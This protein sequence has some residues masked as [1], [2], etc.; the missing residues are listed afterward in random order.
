MNFE[1]KMVAFGY[2]AKE[3][4]S[5]FQTESLAKVLDKIQFDSLTNKEKSIWAKPIHFTIPNGEGFRRLI[6]IPSPLHQIL[7]CKLISENW[8]QLQVFFRQ[9]NISM[10]TPVVSTEENIA[11]ESKINIKEKMNIRMRY[12]HNK[13]YILQTDISRFYPTIY[14]HVIPW[15]YHTKDYIKKNLNKKSLLGNKIDSRIQ[16]MQDGQTFGIP[17]GPATSQVISEIVAT[18][19]DVDFKE[20][21]DSEVPG[22]RYTDD[23]EY[24]FDTEEVAKEALSKIH[25]VVNTYQLE[26]NPIKTKIIKAP[27]AFEPEWKQYFSR[28]FFRKTVLGQ[29]SD[30][31]SYFSRAFSF[32]HSSQDKGVLQY[33]L[34]KVRSEIIFEE[35]WDIFESLLLHSAFSDHSTL[36]VVLEIIELYIIKNYQINQERFKEFLEKL[37]KLNIHQENHFEVCWALVYSKRIEISLSKEVTNLL[38]N[39]EDSITCILT[40]ILSNKGLLEGNLNFNKY[41]RY[42]N[43]EE[44]YGSNWLFAYEAFKQGWLR[45]YSNPDYVLEDSFFKI[46]YQNDVSFLQDEVSLYELRDMMIVS[47]TVESKDETEISEGET[48]AEE[49]KDETEIPK[50]EAEAEE[51]KDET[52]ISEGETEAEES[53]DETEISEG[54]T[55]A[56]ESK[57]ETEISEGETEAEESKDET[58]ISEGEI[59]AEESKDETEI[60]EGETTPEEILKLHS[61]MKN[62][63]YKNNAWLIQGIDTNFK[64]DKNI[65]TYLG[66]EGY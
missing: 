28:Y 61:K 42:L 62:T 45:P 56:E 18:A 60:S 21:I 36:P 16:F 44:L 41:K 6:S 47:S 59:E 19:I 14:T 65:S 11:I 26:L 9:S 53:K 34:K 64:K 23:I 2:L 7:L 10:T 33:A 55:E 46:L 4:P 51:S 12:L 30:L 5:E 43:K 63:I 49:S 24:Y 38:L 25:K 32:K 1:Q 20:L 27:V 37:I 57:D 13:N 31:N 52:E 50:G 40:M 48:E 39:A 8:E 66:D 29:R 3:I 54:E 22:F 35:N 58:E 15:A 17:I